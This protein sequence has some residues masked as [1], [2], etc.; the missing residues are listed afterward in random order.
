MRRPAW[1]SALLS[2]A[3]VERMVQTRVARTA[4]LPP[5]GSTMAARFFRGAHMDLGVGAA[6]KLP[7]GGRKDLAIQALAGTETVSDLGAR[8]GVSRKFVYAQA[9]KAR[10]ALDD[11]FPAAAPE[12]AVLFNLAVTKTWLRQI[13]TRRSNT[14]HNLAHAA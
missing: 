14:Y 13:L 1:P 7:E 8:H 3:H 10:A 2:G 5:P 12:N 11:A 9:G 6:A 4:E